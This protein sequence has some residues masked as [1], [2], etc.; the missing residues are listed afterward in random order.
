MLLLYPNAEGTLERYANRWVSSRRIVRNWDEM[1]MTL[2]KLVEA[3]PQPSGWLI[4]LASIAVVVSGLVM[5]VR[6]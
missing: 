6:V 1:N 3:H 4:T 5:L 2:D